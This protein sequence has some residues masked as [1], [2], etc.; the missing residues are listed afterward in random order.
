MESPAELSEEKKKEIFDEI[1]ADW[2]KGKGASKESNEEENT[3][4]SEEEKTEE[5]IEIAE[6]EVPTTDETPSE[7]NIE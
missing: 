2:E 3:E 7:E 6:D 1:S 5:S 4:D